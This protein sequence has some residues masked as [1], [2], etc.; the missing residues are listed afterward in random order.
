MLSAAVLT[1]TPLWSVMPEEEI[2]SSS[3][4]YHIPQ[5]AA[6]MWQDREQQY[7]ITVAQLLAQITEPVAQAFAREPSEQA[8]IFGG[9][10][11]SYYRLARLGEEDTQLIIG[12]DYN[13]T[14][15]Q[16]KINHLALLP[17]NT[18]LYFEYAENAYWEDGFCTHI[19]F[20]NY[21]EKKHLTTEDEYFHYNLLIN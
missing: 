10:H 3:I 2:Q 4:T 14:D 16:T 18:P 8:P 12:G 19:Y 11:R 20:N 9:A 17:A 7:Q 5:H 6:D 21:P 1:T 15:A 13:P